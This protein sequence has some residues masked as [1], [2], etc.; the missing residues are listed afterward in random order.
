MFI[1]LKANLIDYGV[2][3]GDSL[4]TKGDDEGFL[5]NFGFNFPY[6]NQVFQSCYIS[7]NGF[8][9]FEVD[10]SSPSFKFPA[11]DKSLITLFWS[12][13][14]TQISGNIFYRSIMNTATLNLIGN[15]VSSS[16]IGVNFS[17]INAFVITYDSVPHYSVNI[18]GNVT[19]QIIISTDNI[20]SFLTINYGDLYLN[21]S[22]FYEP[23]YQFANDMAYYGKKNLFPSIYVSRITDGFRQ[24]NVNQSGKFIYQLL[25]SKKKLF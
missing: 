14:C 2:N 9:S 6:F 8:I 21:S 4:L 15:E 1:I 20:Q 3:F 16:L 19:I 18:K 17:P 11:T 24:S 10:I 5:V 12:D 25:N 22:T 13:L 7:I 23:I